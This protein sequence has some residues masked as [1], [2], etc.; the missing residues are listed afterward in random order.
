MERRS[1]LAAV[2]IAALAVFLTGCSRSP[3]AP[4][5]DTTAA[6]GAGTAVMSP[7]PDN[8]PPSDGGTPGSHTVMLPASGEGTLTVGRFTLWIRKN[9]LKMP[10]T[11]TMHV[12]DPEAMDVQ[13]DVQPAAANDFRSPVVLT[14]NMSDVADVDYDTVTM[15]YWDGAWKQATDVA[16]HPRLQEVAGFFFSL[17]NCSVANGGGKK[18]KLGA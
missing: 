11:I 9:S 6:P 7:I 2:T 4:T 13:I 1:S 14:A 10:A 5:A 15:M 16:T 12:S 8:P 18:N 3:V 17:S